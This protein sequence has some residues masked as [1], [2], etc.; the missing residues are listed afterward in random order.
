MR[1]LAT[2]DAKDYQDTTGICEKY[3]VRGIIMREGRLAM[4]CSREGEFKIPGGGMEAGEDI[5]EA[6]TREVHEETGYLVIAD[7]VQEL[8]E[9]TE[10]RRDIF[11]PTK[12]YI[13]HSLFYA[14]QT[15]DRQD[16]L[17]LTPSEIAK[18]YTLRWATPEEICQRN[19]AAKDPWII[20]DTAFVR[21]LL[22]GRVALPAD[23]VIQRVAEP[24]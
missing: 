5:V 21:M 17:A 1:I 2:F 3:S 14:C 8:G 13:C 4:Q 18:G 20:R 15:G 24:V 12:K 11:D 10:L 7:T 22:D 6:L 19:D 16:A 9:I 23:C